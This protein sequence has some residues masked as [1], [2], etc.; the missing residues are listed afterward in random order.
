MGAKGGVKFLFSLLLEIGRSNINTISLYYSK[1]FNKIIFA[2]GVPGG[3]GAMFFFLLIIIRDLHIYQRHF[4][5]NLYISENIHRD[6]QL[7]KL[8]KVLVFR[9]F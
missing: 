4:F 2:R 6:K 9:V 5:F 8:V 1:K 3:E 7:F